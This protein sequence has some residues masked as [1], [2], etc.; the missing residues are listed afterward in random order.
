MDDITYA[1]P[2]NAEVGCTVENT[3]LKNMFH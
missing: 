2:M 3:H 1:A